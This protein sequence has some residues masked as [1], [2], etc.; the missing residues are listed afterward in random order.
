MMSK[1]L[2][3]LWSLERLHKA[4]IQIQHSGGSWEVIHD[5]KR[6]SRKYREYSPHVM[7]VT[8]EECETIE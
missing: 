1:R 2:E 5:G 4:F 8:I 7:L 6:F 3:K